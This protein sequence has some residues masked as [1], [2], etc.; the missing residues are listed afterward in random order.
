MRIK[1][2]FIFAK[3]VSSSTE[4]KFGENLVR[5]WVEF[6]KKLVLGISGLQ[7]SKNR[8]F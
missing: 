1:F 8:H 7:G 4:V 2:Y 5:I 6:D 3:I